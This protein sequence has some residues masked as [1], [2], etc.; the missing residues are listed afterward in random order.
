MLDIESIPIAFYNYLKFLYSIKKATHVEPTQTRSDFLETTVKHQRSTS[1]TRQSEREITLFIQLEINEIRCSEQRGE[2]FFSEFYSPGS[3]STSPP[4][5][6]PF[7]T[8]FFSF[9][10]SFSSFNCIPSIPDTKQRGYNRNEIFPKRS[11]G[12]DSRRTT[13]RTRW[14]AWFVFTAKWEVAKRNVGWK[15]ISFISQGTLVPRCGRRIACR[16]RVSRTNERTI[17]LQPREP[18]LLGNEIHLCNGKRDRD[19]FSRLARS[20]DS[21][22]L[23]TAAALKSVTS[24]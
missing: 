5:F 9:L 8:N 21:L 23:A 18:F 16:Q 24:V 1:T 2:I 4:S 19:G 10:F 14:L 6:F 17:V 20:A 3:R 22:L 7:A 13:S 15:C 12:N 11:R